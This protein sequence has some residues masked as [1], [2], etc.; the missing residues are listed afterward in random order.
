MKIEAARTAVLDYIKR[1]KDALGAAIDRKEEGGFIEA[2]KIID[3][4]LRSKL[5][6]PHKMDHCMLFRAS[7]E[8]I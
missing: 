7:N 5:E 4:V 1:F 3:D 8:R 6:K 2:S